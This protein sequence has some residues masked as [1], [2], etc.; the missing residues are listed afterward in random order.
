MDEMKKKLQKSKPNLRKPRNPHA[1]DAKMRH[2]GPHKD[3]KSKKERHREAIE[4][5]LGGYYRD[6]E[7]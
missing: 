7:A 1:T 4:E 6:G 2:A 5:G 3:K